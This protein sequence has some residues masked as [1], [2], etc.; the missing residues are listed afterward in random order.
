MGVK[1]EVT[2]VTGEYKTRDGETKKRYMK[3][4]VILDTKTGPMLKLETVPLGWDGFAY[5]N[6]PKE[7]E[8]RA[9]DDGA[10]VPF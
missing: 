3:I 9:R 10:D 7:R 4:G 6:E 1:Y 5:L 8:P 2:A